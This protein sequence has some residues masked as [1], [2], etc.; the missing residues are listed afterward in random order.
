MLIVLLAGAAAGA[1]NA[2][3]GSGTLFTFPVLLS[4]G[5]P[6]V[7]ATMSN[8]IG[9]VAG[10]VSGTWGYRRELAGQRRRVFRLLPA[11]LLGAV[12]GAWLL[13]RLPEET[14]EAVVPVLLVLALVLVVTQTRIQRALARRREREAAKGPKR[15]GRS[16]REPAAFGATYLIGVYGGYFTA[17]QGILLVG[18][19]GVLVPETLQ[20]VNALKNLLALAVNVV[21]ACT[22]TIVAYDRI[23]WTAAGLIAVGSLAGGF[24]GASVGRRLHP[25]VLRGVIVVLGVVGIWRIL[26]A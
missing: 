14:F 15:E 24:V 8:A 6:P 5:F 16:G 18:A 4:L 11:S 22:Y 23:S 26:A 20:R 10:S 1:I 9:L 13:L 25:A 12:T 3:I 2:V 7:T 21:A 17:A 19:L